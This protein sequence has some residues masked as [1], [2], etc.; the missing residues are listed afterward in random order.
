MGDYTNCYAQMSLILF[1]KNLLVNE[2]EFLNTIVRVIPRS[3]MSIPGQ[4]P[5]TNSVWQL[6]VKISACHHHLHSLFDQAFDQALT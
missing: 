2:R 5:V 3:Q 6:P 4:M 1:T